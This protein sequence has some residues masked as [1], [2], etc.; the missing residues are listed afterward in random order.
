MIT[1]TNESTRGACL[2]EWGAKTLR[3]LPPEV[4]HEV[5]LATLKS[6][7]LGRL[8]PRP[9]KWEAHLASSLKGLGP[10]PHPIGLAAGFDKNGEVVE[11]LHDLGF[12][13]VEVGT[14]TPLPQA[15]NPKPRIF[16]H[17][18]ERALVNRLGFNSRGLEKM[19]A[20]LARV[21]NGLSAVP[22]LINVGKN[23]ET[24]DEDALWDFVQ[25]IRAM[26]EFSRSFVVNLSS[27]NTPGLRDL[28]EPGF[29]RRLAAV[30]D[31]EYEARPNVWIKLSPDMAKRDFQ[32][33]I[34]C[35]E[36]CRFSG[37]TVSNT[38]RVEKPES[39]GMSGH[40]LL[41]LSTRCL[42]W[43]WEVHQGRLEMVGVG[44]VLSGADVFQKLI[45]GASVVQV[46]TAMIY[47]GPWVVHALLDELQRELALAGFTSVTE[48]IGSFYD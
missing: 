32:T 24:S 1:K 11:G 15:G 14:V 29:L 36:E 28:A 47:R 21:G 20:N 16:R 6:G 2:G 30:L 12:A 25:G 31:Q 33:L 5:A 17:P 23:K 40:P 27:P 39:G 38:H 13:F 41:V 10:L 22:L 35:V 9:N 18:A 3:V 26:H 37:I 43:A 34:E 46:M 45:R 7:M 44:G 48:A 19:R 4:A 42:E 8:V